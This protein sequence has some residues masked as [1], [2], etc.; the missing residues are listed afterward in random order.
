[1]IIVVKMMDIIKRNTFIIKLYKDDLGSY[2]I[3]THKCLL[4]LN[5]SGLSSTININQISEFARTREYYY[6]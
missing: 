4:S 3:Q 5:E 2:F 1:M 6:T